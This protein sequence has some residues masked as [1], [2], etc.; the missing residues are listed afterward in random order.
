MKKSTKYI[1]TLVLAA[2]ATFTGC[3]V[4]VTDDTREIITSQRMNAEDFGN[5]LEQDEAVPGYVREWVAEE[6]ISW[7]LLEAWSRGLDPDAE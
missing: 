2:T 1:A 7:Q 4:V 6:A 5:A 3:A